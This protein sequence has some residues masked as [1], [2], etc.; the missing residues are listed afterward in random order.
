M[1]QLRQADDL[2][3]RGWKLIARA[4]DRMFAVS[5]AWGCTGTK[6]NIRDVITEARSLMKFIEW[7]KA[8]R[9]LSNEQPSTTPNGSPLRRTG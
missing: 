7:A 1:M 4:P 9:E 2:T 8:N 3:E 5:V 6:A